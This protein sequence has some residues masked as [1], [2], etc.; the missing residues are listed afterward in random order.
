MKRL[1]IKV[2]ARYRTVE[3]ARI[4][5]LLLLCGWAFEV[6]ADGRASAEREATEAL[7]RWVGLGLPF[8]RS[9]GGKRCFDAAEVANFLKWV[10]IHDRDPFWEERFVTTGR[11]LVWDFH[12]GEPTRS[13]P[14]PPIVL[15]PQRF[16]VTLR[17]EFNLQ[18]CTPGA[19]VRLRLPL[20]LEDGA[21][22]DLKVVSIPP[23]DIEVEFAIAPGRLDARLLV[24][25][26][27][28][29][30]L[31]VQ[32]G[33][34]AYPTI[35]GQ[36]LAPLPPSEIELYTRPSEGLIQI[37]PQV[38]ALAAELAGSARE[39]WALVRG[40]WNF[41]LD[42]LTCGVV[43]YDQLDIVP[44]TDW[45]LETGWFDCH[46]GSAL[47]VALCRAK[48]IPARIVGGYLLYSPSPSPHFWAEVWMEGRG[49]VPLDTICSDL[50]ARG[51][52]RP[53]RDY[54]AGQLDYRMKTQCF[55]R[56]FNSTPTIRLPQAWHMLARP[57]GEGA[58]IGF[59]ANDS[60]SLVY[61]DGISVRREGGP[62]AG[63]R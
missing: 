36:Q 27:R 30:T 61:R 33:F 11:R 6:R 37:S 10:G 8:E 34:T 22:R 26:K 54:F 48:G 18:G 56:F 52:D 1:G 59:F 55:P 2:G 42:R 44:P 50:S 32:V 45:V 60:G 16:S 58:E 53:W 3:E 14:P 25:R 49:W 23:P 21:L 17:R 39:P 7:N 9:D 15:G 41:M 13:M 47:L 28:T 43:H 35:P 4:I 24:P 5:E 38:R 29:V 51:R 63:S 57:D 12:P 62:A 46:L 20:P 19:R 40:F 31:A